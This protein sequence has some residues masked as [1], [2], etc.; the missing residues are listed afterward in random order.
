MESQE[1]LTEY[2]A[3][4]NKLKKRFLR[5]PNVAEASDNFRW[6]EWQLAA[7]TE[8][9]YDSRPSVLQWLKLAGGHLML[10]GAIF[11]LHKCNFLIRYDIMMR[12]GIIDVRLCQS[13]TI[14]LSY[15]DTC[16]LL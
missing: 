15:L 10:L 16:I 5:R 1:F 7:V 2:K 13:H 8:I 9:S 6:D 12:G 4:S 11:F 3:I 14:F